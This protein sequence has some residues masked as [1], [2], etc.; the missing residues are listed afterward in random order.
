MMLRITPHNSDEVATFLINKSGHCTSQRD[1]RL[2]GI[3]W[4]NLSFTKKEEI[5]GVIVRGRSTHFI[6]DYNDEW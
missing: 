2:H 6:I 4:I 1:F 3:L 5:F